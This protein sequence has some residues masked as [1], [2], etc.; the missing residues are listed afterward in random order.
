MVVLNLS[1]DRIYRAVNALRGDTSLNS[2]VAGRRPN[3]IISGREAKVSDSIKSVADKNST[4]AKQIGLMRIPLGGRPS[5]SADV[6][7]DNVH[8]RRV[9]DDLLHVDVPLASPTEVFYEI[10]GDELLVTCDPRTLPSAGARNGQIDT[11]GLYSLLQFGAVV[12]PA[13]IW[14]SIRRFRPGRTTEISLQN[15]LIGEL[16]LA[17][18]STFNHRETEVGTSIDDSTDGLERLIDATL[19]VVC[20]DG[21]PVILF[22]GGVDSGLLAA[23]AAAKGWNDT[24]LVNFA[25][26]SDDLE[27]ECAE[28]M[29]KHLGLKFVRLE[30]AGPPDVEWLRSLVGHC[31]HPFGDHSVMPTFSLC[32]GACERVE[33]ERVIIDGT[34][35]DGVFGL[36]AKARSMRRLYK[37]PSFVR[38]MPAA[39]YGISS[40]W[41]R[42]SRFEYMARIFCRSLYMTPPVTGIALNSL[43]D[44]AY[45]FPA[46]VVSQCLNNLN[47]WIAAAMP[48]NSPEQILPALDV[49]LVCSGIYAQKS[50]ACFE[51]HHRRVVYPFLDPTFLKNTLGKKPPKADECRPKAVMK[52][53]LAK[54][55]PNQLVYRPKRGFVAAS[56]LRMTEPVWPELLDECL[57]DDVLRHV[58]V[59][60]AWKGIRRLL[61]RHEI[62]P[63]PIYHLIWTVVFFYLWRQALSG[64][65]FDGLS[66]NGDV[67]R[68]NGM[69]D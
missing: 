42:N 65:D 22:S 47:D 69:V 52:R 34:G 61:T 7:I 18:T 6:Q 49:A 38:A 27:S 59:T 48:G 25:F 39:T 45:R 24:T 29:A 2:R 58:L 60:P 20:P 8:L 62:L 51:A 68:A 16:D 40:C 67:M 11:V 32:Q 37:I 28:T 26:S 19:D 17:G 50:R 41:L 33:P 63:E 10:S 23:R 5:L 57:S 9:S 64:H 14:R 12:P 55:V 36:L 15:G 21:N 4:T 31:Q 56:P 53:L 3:S 66:D 43:H 30:A 13:S 35:A 1:A 54:S 44:I 46:R